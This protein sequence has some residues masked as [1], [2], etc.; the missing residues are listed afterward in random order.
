MYSYCTL[1]MMC[2]YF[3]YS[4]S[5]L[6]IL[7]GKFNRKSMNLVCIIMIDLSI[8]QMLSINLLSKMTKLDTHLQ[9]TYQSASLAILKTSL[10]RKS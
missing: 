5:Q 7:I 4:P 6:F 8:D 3:K 10:D 1:W 2:V 9:L